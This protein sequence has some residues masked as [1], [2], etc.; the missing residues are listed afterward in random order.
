MKRLLNT[1]T[2]FKKTK[3]KKESKEKKDNLA[4]HNKKKTYSL[5]NLFVIYH[6]VRNLYLVLP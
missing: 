1:Y 2:K 4:M 5:T 3:I 6:A